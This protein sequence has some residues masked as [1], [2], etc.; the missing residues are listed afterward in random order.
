MTIDPNLIEVNEITDIFSFLQAIE[1]KSEKWLWL[2]GIFHISV[3]VLAFILSL[4]FQIILFAILLL[5]V[6]FSEFFNELAAKNSYMFSKNQY[7]DSN[8]L[9]ISIIFCCPI[10]INCLFILARW[11]MMSFD[12]M[13]KVKCA[14]LKARQR[15]QN[16]VS[17]K[18]D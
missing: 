12:L 17:K 3:S 1:W 4:N 16:T 13:T 15:Q 10:L 18:S 2:V 6:Y 11:L 8:G 9:F 7:F 5:L 14:Q